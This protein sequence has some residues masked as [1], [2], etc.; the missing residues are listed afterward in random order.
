MVKGQSYAFKV[1]ANTGYVFNSAVSI[2]LSYNT[3]QITLSDDRKTAT[4]YG[5]DME[6]FPVNYAQITITAQAQ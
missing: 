4:Y 1:T 2:R 3:Y 6:P 5:A